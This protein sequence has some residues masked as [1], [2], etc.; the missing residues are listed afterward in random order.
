MATLRKTYSPKAAEIR[1]NWRVIDAADRPLGRVA[2]EIAGILHGKDKATFTP[3]A[4]TG[5]FVV[6]VNAAKVRVTG[7]KI[8]KKFY[9]SHSMYPGGFK[10]VSF[11]MMLARHPRRVIELAVWGMLP[12]NRLGRALLRKLKV[13]AEGSHPHG[14]QAKELAAPERPGRPGHKPPRKLRV[15]KTAPPAAA[16]PSAAETPAGPAAP[17]R[18]RRAPEAAPVQPEVATMTESQVA[19]PVA[20][21]KEAPA[22][23]PSAGPIKREPS[24][25]RSRRA[26]AGQAK[27]GGEAAAPPQA[28][29]AGESTAKSEEA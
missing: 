7:Q 4:D 17:R 11:E 23:A 18:R 29:P 26:R 2:S 24:R 20:E 10:A 8:T 1:R 16:A 21:A 25:P 19:G 28:P 13:Y 12:K 3:F 5:D 27:A 6:V 15:V 9:Y 14:A 22:Q